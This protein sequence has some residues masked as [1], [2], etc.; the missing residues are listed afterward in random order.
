MGSGLVLKMTG[1]YSWVLG[2]FLGME[3]M[4]LFYGR[5]HCPGSCRLPETSTSRASS[6]DCLLYRVDKSF[7]D[8]VFLPFFMVLG[9]VNNQFNVGFLFVVFLL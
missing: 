8:L 7:E 5:A 4:L 1:L 2:V 6:S 9:Y 3:N